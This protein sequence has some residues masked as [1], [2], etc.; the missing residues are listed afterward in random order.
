MQQIDQNEIISKVAVNIITEIF[1]NSLCG[2]KEVHTWV[3]SKSKKHDLLKLSSGKYVSKLENLYSE[4]RIIGMQKPVPLR[5]I[6]VNVNVLEG[7]SSLQVL[8]VK[9][10]EELFQQ[11]GIHKEIDK[12]SQ[13]EQRQR[14]EKSDEVARIKQVRKTIP[15]I[16]VI[17]DEDKIFLLGKPGAGKTTFLKSILLAAL[18]GKLNNK[19][20]PIYVNL[21]DWSD[22]NE[23]LFGFIN[24]Q[25]KICD[26]PNSQLFVS[27]ILEKGKCIVL[28]DG[29]DEALDSTKD[30]IRELNSFIDQY[31]DNKIIISCRIAASNYVFEKFTEVEI[32]DFD[33][34]Q[35]KQ[36]INNWFYND[37]YKAKT[38]WNEINISDN[39]RIKE[40]ACT[41]LLLTLIC[42]TFENSLSFPNNK[43][44]LYKEALDILLK[45]WDS[46]RNIKREIVYK[47]L[48]LR[49]KETLLSQIA[50]NTF[51]QNQYFF[52]RNIAELYIKKFITNLNNI[53][54]NSVD[55]DSQIILNSIEAH[56]GLLVERAKNI[57][58]FSHLTLHEY[59]TARYL[60]D[61]LIKEEIT[62]TIQTNLLNTKWRE[63]FIITAGILPG[64]DDFLLKM[65]TEIL[66]R[67]NQE[68]LCDIV[69]N[70]YSIIRRD[71]FFP[72]EIRRALALYYT[73]DLEFPRKTAREIGV[74]LTPTRTSILALIN[75]LANSYSKKEKFS[76]VVN[77][78]NNIRYDD[79]RNFLVDLNKALNFNSKIT[80]SSGKEIKIDKSRIDILNEYI[81]VNRTLID[82][83]NSDAYVTNET[84]KKIHDNV[85]KVISG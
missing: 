70:S 19:L 15:G 5:K 43:A 77:L 7:I 29:L 61:N 72:I 21:K 54:V 67:F 17:N 4:I 81:Q 6:F 73:L 64:S 79:T 56:H 38:C 66:K 82:C 45:T 40:L 76:S 47:A 50:Y 2:I 23:N 58:S 48:S 1:K 8:S 10:L 31:L 33:E 75:S 24:S 32:A 51:K 42:I 28:F 52:K 9:Q 65:Q 83:L 55:V 41:P 30:I 71:N 18:D 44:E 39:R 36:F 62:S 80:Q 84:R 46:S 26:F 53:D 25:F 12:L 37:Q 22:S 20:I 34:L 13:L 63:V 11:D 35:I 27:N 60:V 3:S 78:S 49:K 57:Y 69:T 16:Q 14:G 85:L 59:F 74:K 68:T